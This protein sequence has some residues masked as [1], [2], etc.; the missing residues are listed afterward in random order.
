MRPKRERKIIEK[1]G[2]QVTQGHAG[3]AAISGWSGGVPLNPKA[4]LGKTNKNLMNTPLVQGLG[5]AYKMP[6]SF[7]PNI[8]IRIQSIRIFAFSILQFL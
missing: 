6:I 2:T 7:G 3:S 5:G 1:K 8:I 4:N